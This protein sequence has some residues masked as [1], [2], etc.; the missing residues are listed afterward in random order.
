MIAWALKPIGGF[1]LR[2]AVV[3]LVYLLAGVRR[4]GVG[5]IGKRLHGHDSSG[6]PPLPLIFPSPLSVIVDFLHV[7]KHSTF[8]LFAEGSCCLDLL[9]AVTIRR[10]LSR[11]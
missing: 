4:L 6:S 3:G 11:S 8:H 1:C 9:I 10:D 7:L 2:N 5:K